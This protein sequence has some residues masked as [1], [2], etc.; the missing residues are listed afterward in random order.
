VAPHRNV[1]VKCGDFVGPRELI[2]DL[3]TARHVIPTFIIFLR[4]GIEASMIVAIL[5][6]YLQRIGQR[7]H[8]VDVFWGVTSA[9]VLVTC[10]GVAAFFLIRQYDGS[11]VQTYFETTTYVFAAGVMTFMTFW[12]QRHAKGMSKELERRSNQA[13]SN[14]GRWGIRLLAFQAVGREGLETMVFTLAIVFASSRQAA[15]PTRGNLVLVGA[16]LGL[17]A[18]LVLAFAIYKL[19]QESTCASSSAYLVRRSWC[20]PRGFSLTQSRICSVCTGYPSVGVCSGT[21]LAR[22]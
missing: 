22:F 18:A 9:M 7:R 5:L 13:L 3:P 1:L 4:E 14:G 19:G 11:N 10:G 6:A 8:F 16:A 2:S 21:L 15:A 17:A 20:S 12:M